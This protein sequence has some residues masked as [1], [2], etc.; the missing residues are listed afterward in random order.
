MSPSKYNT[1]KCFDASIAVIG[2]V[3]VEKHH[4]EIRLRS[5]VISAVGTTGAL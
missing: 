2:A 5:L 4:D 1:E 3:V